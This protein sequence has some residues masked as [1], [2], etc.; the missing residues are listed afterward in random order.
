VRHGTG[1]R[2]FEG[3]KA[4]PADLLDVLAMAT[5][6]EKVNGVLL[7]GGEQNLC[8]SGQIQCSASAQGNLGV[9]PLRS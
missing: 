8:L 9:P 4:A 2:D 3:T 5:A 1:V 6:T 7:D